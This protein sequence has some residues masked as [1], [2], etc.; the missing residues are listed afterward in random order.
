MAEIQSHAVDT[1]SAD[2]F[3]LVPLGRHVFKFLNSHCKSPGLET[4][5]L[6]G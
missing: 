3:V 6:I 4:S 2:A 5:N 1:N